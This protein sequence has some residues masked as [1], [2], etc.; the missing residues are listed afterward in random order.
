MSL[1]RWCWLL[2]AGGWVGCKG[3]DLIVGSRDVGAPALTDA[4][5]DDGAANGPSAPACLVPLAAHL[6]Q[7]DP[8]DLGCAS[9]L[10]QSSSFAAF[11]MACPSGYY[12]MTCGDSSGN[13]PLA[14]ALGCAAPAFGPPHNRFYCCPCAEPLDGGTPALDASDGGPAGSPSTIAISTCTASGGDPDAS[15]T[16]GAGYVG[17]QPSE[18]AAALGPLHPVATAADI[19]GLLS[20]PWYSCSGSVFGI[21]VPG[22]IGLQ[23]SSDGHYAVLEDSN[24]SLVAVSSMSD[25]GSAAGTYVVV[26]GSASYGPGTFELQI[27]PATGGLFLGQVVVYDSPRQFQFFA[28]NAGPVV[29]SRAAP[30][31]PRAGVCSC[32]QADGTMVG[33]TD[34]TALAAAMTGRWIW[35][36]G[37]PPP[38]IGVPMGIEFTS[39]GSWYELEEDADGTVARATDELN[40]N[41]FHLVPTASFPPGV[42]LGPEPLALE[43]DSMT[44]GEITQVVVTSNPRTLFLAAGTMDSADGG[45]TNFY[46]ILFPSP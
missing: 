4:A 40:H 46:S 14:A 25:A 11:P 41:T 22:A 16:L 13:D 1:R 18:C 23:F 9:Q 6:D 43:M 38:G 2:V 39:D 17:L 26:D 44:Q 28:T 37:S 5:S 7:P 15:A 10:S 20:G 35:C 34:S 30:W 31:S 8:M 24:D 36:A 33:Q 42:R 29:F 45:L 32:V 21:A 12:Y 3:Q 27:H 19:T